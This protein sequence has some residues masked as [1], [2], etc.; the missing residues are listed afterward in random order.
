MGHSNADIVTEIAEYI[1]ANTMSKSYLK[2]I[3]NLFLFTIIYFVKFIK[4]RKR[5]KNTINCS[6]NVV[7]FV[8]ACLQ[9]NYIQLISYKWYLECTLVQWR[10]SIYS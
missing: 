8:H 2:H 7:P 4:S 9:R 6:V 1:I 3:S 10:L 5:E